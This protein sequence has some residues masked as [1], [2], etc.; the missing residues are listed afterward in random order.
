MT[1]PYKEL[2]S[3]IEK[4]MAGHAAR[5]VSGTPCE[6]G[7]VTAGGL[8]LD[9]FKYEIKDYLVADWLIRQE[10]PQP[11]RVIK[12]AA[13]VNADGS[14]IPNSTVYSHFTRIDYQGG[15]GADKIEDVR[16]NLSVSLKPGDRV[17]VI[18]VNG[19]QDFVVICK[20]V[21]NA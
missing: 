16:H 11:R 8:K 9:S 5:A 14:D 13:P 6:L 17:L 18:P 10:I 1:N 2:A 21:P 19:G 15:G 3:V 20:V 4:R 7:T 12:T